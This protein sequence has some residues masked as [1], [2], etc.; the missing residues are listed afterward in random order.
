MKDLTKGNIYKTFILFAIPLILSGVLSQCYNLIDTVI[1]GKYLGDT[2]LAAIGSTSAFVTFC[3]SIFWGFA[4]GASV[5]IAS[6]FGAKKYQP[7][8]NSSG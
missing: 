6:L 8:E 4:N 3:S 5:Q 2:G 7:E 1:A